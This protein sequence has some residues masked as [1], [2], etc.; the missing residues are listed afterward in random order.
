LEIETIRFLK[1]GKMEKLNVAVIGVGGIGGYFGAKLVNASSN[2]EFSIDTFFVARG[3]HLETIKGKGL[4]LKSPEFEKI[5]CKPVL[6]TEKISDLPPIDIFLICVK[7][8]DL[9]ETAISIRDRVKD[10]TVILPPLNGADIHDRLRSEIKIGI[11]LPTAVYISGHIEEPGVVVHVGKPGKLIF[12]KDPRH[13]DFVPRNLFRV[14][15]KASIDYEW[16]ED[17]DPTIWEKYI[18]IASYGLVSARYNRTL[19]E[20]LETPSLKEEVAGIMN[21]INLIAIKKKIRLPEEIIDLSLNK[22]LMF[23]PGTQTSLQRDIRQGKKKTELELFGGTIVDLGKKWGVPTPVTEKIYREL[24][25]P[26]DR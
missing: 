9:K 1:E 16:K 19:S 18:F 17:A 4:T 23:P 15:D 20:I 13:S 2:S 21:E 10:N 8:Y 22:A 12:G 3:K 7:G 6:A 14:F 26:G 25:D 11:I 24:N 5:I